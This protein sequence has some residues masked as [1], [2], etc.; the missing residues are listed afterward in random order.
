MNQWKVKMMKL[1]IKPLLQVS[2]YPGV[3]S[4][5]LSFLLSENC[6]DDGH[7][8]WKDPQCNTKETEYESGQDHLQSWTLRRKNALSKTYVCII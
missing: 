7:M 8:L 2:I 5:K 1:P 3:L 4:G 6:C